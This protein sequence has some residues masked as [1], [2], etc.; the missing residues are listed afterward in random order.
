MKTTRIILGLAFND[1]Q[2]I[3]RLSFQLVG[4][5]DRAGATA[6]YT[7]GI[8]TRFLKSLAVPFRALGDFRSTVDRLASPDSVKSLEWSYPTSPTA[9]SYGHAAGCWSAKLGTPGLPSIVVLTFAPA[10]F[11]RALDYVRRLPFPWS[12]ITLHVHPE[13]AEAVAS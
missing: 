7:H 6:D 8:C 10:E 12:P 1:A 3:R 2:G 11:D 9:E 13:Y 5:N 4:Q